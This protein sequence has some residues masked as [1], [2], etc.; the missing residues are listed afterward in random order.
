MIRSSGEV[1]LGNKQAATELTPIRKYS[2]PRYELV[3]VGDLESHPQLTENRRRWDLERSWA[4]CQ[5]IAYT[6]LGS[7]C[8]VGL[9]IWG[10]MS[11]QSR[12]IS[13]SSPGNHL[14]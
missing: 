9:I 3:L 1:I 11:A 8:L 4:T 10:F 6:I 7:A 14:R 13:S 5:M 2:R 12:K